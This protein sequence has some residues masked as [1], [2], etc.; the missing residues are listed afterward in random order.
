MYL[1]NSRDCKKYIS[2][3]RRV[4]FAGCFSL[5]AS[6][7]LIRP[8]LF[9]GISYR[10]KS[11]RIKGTLYDGLRG[12][13]LS[14][15]FSPRQ[16]VHLPPPSSPSSP[17]S[18]SFDLAVVDALR[19]C[20]LARFPLYCILDLTMINHSY[21][22][23]F[24]FLAVALNTITSLAL[25]GEDYTCDE[26]SEVVEWVSKKYIKYF[27]RERF[28]CESIRHVNKR[29]GVT[30]CYHTSLGILNVTR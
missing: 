1:K 24:F 29:V 4:Q 8:R 6:P 3:S 28:I 2:P 18:S 11:F 23:I 19:S 26:I 30:C 27:A 10:R 20:P 22:V 7:F 17:S 13:W 12:L 14:S 9:R 15:T 21:C 25:D 16:C 5:V